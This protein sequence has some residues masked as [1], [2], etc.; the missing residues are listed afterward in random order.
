MSHVAFPSSV[1]A[2]AADYVEEVSVPLKFSFKRREYTIEMDEE[3]ISFVDDAKEAI[4][5]MKTPRNLRLLKK[6][7]KEVLLSVT[8]EKLETKI[9]SSMA[10]VWGLVLHPLIDRVVVEEGQDYL[11]NSVLLSWDCDIFAPLERIVDEAGLSV[12]VAGK[13]QRIDAH[14]YINYICS[15]EKK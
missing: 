7:E 15:K 5:T 1:S 8:D 13:R 4:M 14:D 3:L 9:V 2:S 11:E 10:K 12:R 6:S